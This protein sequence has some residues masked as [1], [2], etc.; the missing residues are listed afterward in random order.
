MKK[1]ISKQIDKV[2]T[3]LCD[4]KSYNLVY[5]APKQDEIMPSVENTRRIVEFLREVLFPGYF[6][7]SALKPENMKYYTGVTID[8]IFHR[9]SKEILCCLCFTCKNEKKSNCNKCNELSKNLSAEFISFLP[10][11]RK[12]LTTDVIA[13]YNSDPAAGNYGEVIFCYPAIRALTNYRIAHHLLKLNVP[14][15]PRII[16]EMA[17]SETGID[18]HP[19]AKIGEGLFIDHGTAVVIGETAEIGKNCVLF[20]NVTIGG[21]GKH[22]GKRHPTIGDNVMIGTGATLLGPIKVGNNVKIGAESVIIMHD[23][24]SDCTVIGVPGKIVK[25]NGEKVDIKLGKTL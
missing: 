9:L 23:I 1:N 5:H 21:T 8:K 24:P 11:I 2:I 20:H 6:G 19:G 7:N 22:K 16:T 3:D 25:L 15:L 18:I 4:S 13:A 14:L 10:Q 12:L 17:H